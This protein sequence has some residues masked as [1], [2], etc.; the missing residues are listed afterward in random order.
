MSLP[1]P[2]LNDCNFNDIDR[3]VLFQTGMPHNGRCDPHNVLNIV[4]DGNE[5]APE[6]FKPLVERDVRKDCDG[7]LTGMNISLCTVVKVMTPFLVNFCLNCP[8]SSN[9]RMVHLISFVK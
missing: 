4:F 8:R 7:H 1:K 5:I 9:Q 3:N 2:V 6:L